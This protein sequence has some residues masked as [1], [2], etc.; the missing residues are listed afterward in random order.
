MLITERLKYET[1]RCIEISER[2]KHEQ[3][4]DMEKYEKSKSFNSNCIIEKIEWIQHSKQIKVRIT[5]FETI[6]SGSWKMF[7]NQNG[8]IIIFQ[9][10]KGDFELRLHDEIKSN[11]EYFPT[12]EL[13]RNLIFIVTPKNKKIWPSLTKNNSHKIIPWFDLFSEND[14]SN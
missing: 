14:D 3:F 10:K 13:T 5:T 8:S 4:Q 11:F 1:D 6:R 9:T 7:L 2:I 12:K